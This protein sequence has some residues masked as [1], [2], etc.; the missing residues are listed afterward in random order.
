MSKYFAQPYDLSAYGFFFH[1]EED[2]RERSSLLRNATGQ[3]VEEFELQFIDGM[4][5][6]AALFKA[7]GVNQSNL[8]R[9]LEAERD[10]TEDQKQRFII[11]VGECGYAFDPETGDPDD[12]EVDIY[13]VDSLR[14]LAEQFVDEGLFGG[15]P[16]RLASYIDY[17]AIARDLAVD[18]TE[19]DIAGV[20]L[21]YR[22]G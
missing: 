18:Y 3:H 21:V 8:L 15:I 20:M 7:Y 11:A 22:C 6:D 13:E 14:E 19:T 1:T 9:Y 5:I 12:F 17:D 10:W 2:Y 4:L 16:E